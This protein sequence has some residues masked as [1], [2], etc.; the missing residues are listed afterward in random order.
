MRAVKNTLDDGAVVPGAGAFE[1]AA[2]E[3]LTQWARASVSGKAK[4]GVAAFADG[5]LV[6]PRTLA[7]NSGLDAQDTLLKV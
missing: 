4:L 2:H 7:Q 3:H 6:V 5:L 1:V